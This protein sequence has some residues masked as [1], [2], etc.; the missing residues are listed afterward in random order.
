VTNNWIIETLDNRE[1]AITC[2]LDHL[3]ETG[4]TAIEERGQFCLA[5]SGGSTP[6]EI[7]KRL[8][9]EMLDWSRVQLFWSDERAVPPDHEESNY[10]M[11]MD[12]GFAKLPI[13]PEHIHRMQADFDIEVHAAIYEKLLKEHCDGTLDLLMLGM[14]PDGHTA[15]LFPDTMALHE[16]EQLVVPNYIPKL[17]TWR[18]TLTFPCINRARATAIYVLGADKQQILREVL[19][20]PGLYPI[21]QVKSAL[22][23]TDQS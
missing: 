16:K 18:M 14:G 22:W 2:A 13:P 4:I 3:I 5:L 1:A 17:E 11:A 19:Q 10:R 23:I 20:K 6:K 15:S 8:K 7:Y 21:E 12:A 9:P